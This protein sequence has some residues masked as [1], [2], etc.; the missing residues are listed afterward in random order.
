[1]HPQAFISQP[2]F[3]TEALNVT[4]YQLWTFSD[5]EQLIQIKN[6][7]AYNHIRQQ[8]GRNIAA[9]DW[10]M[11][12]GF[13]KEKFQFFYIN[14]QL[15]APLRC[16]QINANC[17]PVLAS[18]ETGSGSIIKDAWGERVHYCLYRAF[19]SIFPVINQSHDD[20]NSLDEC[21]EKRLLTLAEIALFYQDMSLLIA[22]LKQ[23]QLNVVKFNET[24]ALKAYN[25]LSDENFLT[26]VNL[27][28]V[29]V[30]QGSSNG[31]VIHAAF[32]NDLIKLRQLT[33][34][35]A[36]QNIGLTAYQWQAI[37]RINHNPHL[38]WIMANL[39]PAEVRRE[40]LHFYSE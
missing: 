14:M 16:L 31:Y 34:F 38:P 29:D 28:Q 32:N 33:R 15:P 5:H 37:R 30:T 8:I 9:M 13:G 12:T 23:P 2:F 19:Q 6:I 1:M 35:S 11:F 39:L 4:Q 21:S 18:D 40:Q 17:A 24:A 20:Y 26:F 27:A 3:N 22:I 36:V 7:D 25:Y 10:L